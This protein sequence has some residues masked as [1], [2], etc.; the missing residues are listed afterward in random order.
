MTRKDGQLYLPLKAAASSQNMG[1]ACYEGHFKN[2]SENAIGWQNVH[3]CNGFVNSSAW[4][5]SLVV[6]VDNAIDKTAR[7]NRE[8]RPGPSC[9]W[10]SRPARAIRA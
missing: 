4:V 5:F 9:G 7:R 6:A 1:L 8:Y 10:P 3:G 2:Q